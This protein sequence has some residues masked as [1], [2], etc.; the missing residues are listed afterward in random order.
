MACMRWRGGRLAARPGRDEDEI[1]GGPAGDGAGIDTIITN[2]ARP[3][4]LCDI[5]A[6]RAAGTLFAGRKR[7][8][9]LDT[10]NG[11]VSGVMGSAVTAIVPVGKRCCVKETAMNGSVR[12]Q[13]R[14]NR[15]VNTH[16]RIHL[17]HPDIAGRLVQV[18]QKS[19]K[20]KKKT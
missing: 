13:I 12:P 20:T 4:A 17:Q 15:S 18:Y 19:G 6:G 3:E 14:T 7:I 1:A 9:D 10:G 2:G 8:P 11:D 5:V 16:K